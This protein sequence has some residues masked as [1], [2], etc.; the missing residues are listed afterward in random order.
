MSDRLLPDWIEAYLSYVENTEPALQFKLWTA[1][2][3]IAACLRRKTVLEFGALT[4]YP[5]IYTV[6]VAPSGGRKGTAMGPGYKLLREMGIRM[7]A[8][9]TTREALIKALNTSSDSN[10]DQETGSLG[11][12]SSLTIYSQELTVFIGYNNQQLMS[13]LTDWYDCRDYWT[14]DTKHQGTDAIINVWVNLFGATTPSLLQTTLPQD[15]IGGGLTSRMIFVYAPKKW[16]T[17]A[18]PT[19]KSDMYVSISHDLEQIAMLSGTFKLSSSFISAYEEWY[20]KQDDNPPFDDDRLAGY[21]ERRPNHILKLSMVLGA[22]ESNNLNLELRH[23]ERALKIL[24]DVE[25]SM[26][27]VFKGIGKSGLASLVARMQSIIATK[28]K[29]PY[30]ELINRFLHDADNWSIDKALLQMTS[31]GMIKQV[32]EGNR[33]YVTWVG[34]DLNDYYAVLKGELG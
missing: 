25:A 5:N 11:L 33:A 34:S 31:A 1:I 20:E 10:I 9:A 23:F 8:E 24:T 27:Q 19:Y 14:Y 30:A 7:S 6:L 13:D 17:I 22:S 15:A 21:L 12:H 26:L 3:C 2:S 4:L 28:G 18:Q 32:Q 29:I 16:K